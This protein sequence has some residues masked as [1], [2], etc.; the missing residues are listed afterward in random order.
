MRG[1]IAKWAA[2]TG[3]IDRDGLPLP[4][5][6][7]VIGFTTVLRRWQN[8][9]PEYKTDQPLPNPDDLNKAIPVEEWA[10][11]ID[12]KPR[13]PWA[14]CYVVYLVD[15][16]K[17]ALFTYAHDTFGAM[18]GYNNLEERIAVM[19]VL[20]GE[21]V[22]PIVHL[23]KR[24]WRSQTFGMQM[25]PHFEPTGDWRSPGGIIGSGSPAISPTPTPQLTG[26]TAAPIP[27]QAPSTPTPA[28]APPASA[29][30]PQATPTPRPASATPT[31]STTKSAV[32]D[33][34]K[35]VKPVTMAEVVADEIPWK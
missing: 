12:G 1:T 18:L 28:Q 5:T 22:Y 3:W 20:R 23:E 9:R 11:G 17:A 27:P 15:L 31:A 7:L 4:E 24:P 13:K 26:S 29:S 21:Y 19:R 25:R 32:L 35:P 6:M 30:A 2:N 34:T 16:D 8:N 33:A 10:T 14:Y